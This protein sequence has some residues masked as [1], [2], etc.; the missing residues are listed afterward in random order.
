[1]NA[2]KKEFGDIE[3]RD[4][5]F[6]FAQSLWRYIQECGLSKQYK[7]NPILAFEIKKN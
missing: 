5:H 7:K 2:F 3:I 4:C 1:M 6:Y